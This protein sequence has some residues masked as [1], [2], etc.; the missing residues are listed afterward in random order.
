MS[1]TEQRARGA[2]ADIA[3]FFCDEPDIRSGLDF[4]V[5]RC[6]D[7]FDAAAGV[8]VV[9]E[10]LESVVPVAFSAEPV[11]LLQEFTHAHSEG[12]G[13]Q[14]FTSG[15]RVD[16]ADL[17]EADPRWPGFGALARQLGFTAVHTLPMRLPDRTIGVLT[18]ALGEAAGIEAEE[19]DIAQMLADVGSLGV[20]SYR[21]RQS[22]LL[23]AQLQTA[24]HS[25]VIIEQAKGLLAERM[26][27]SVE[28]AFLHLRAQARSGRQKIHDVAA[29]VIG[30]HLA[31]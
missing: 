12:P 11:K 31:E 3:A 8:M 24:L 19:L 25:R 29:S 10:A 5:A 18:L 26:S 27:I 28:A 14:T 6:V 30:G 7:L 13:F 1:G 21:A 2:L 9:A 22:E 4:L 23:A 17:T 16:C 20:A 15:A